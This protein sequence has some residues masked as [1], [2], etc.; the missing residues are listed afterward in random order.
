MRDLLVFFS[1]LNRLLLETKNL[2][3]LGFDVPPQI[4][5]CYQLS[6]SVELLRR[7]LRQIVRTAAAIAGYK[8]RVPKAQASCATSETAPF[9]WYWLLG[10]DAQ[11]RGQHDEH[12]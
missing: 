10:D 8:L 7:R 11:Q 9:H 3:L 12:I 5:A 6:N 4:L 1:E 2:V